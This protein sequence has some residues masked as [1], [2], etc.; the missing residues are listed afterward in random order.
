MLSLSRSSS[1]L[2]EIS[3]SPAEEAAECFRE[4]QSLYHK[5]LLSEATELLLRTAELD[6]T[7]R[8]CRTQLGNLFQ[9]MDFPEHAVH[10]HAEA[11]KLEPRSLLV[12]LN[13]ACVLPLL[14]QSRE[15]VTHYRQRLNQVLSEIPDDLDPSANDGIDINAHLFY[16]AFYDENIRFTIERYAKHLQKYYGRTQAIAPTRNPTSGRIRIGFLSA[17]FFH[18]SHLRAFEGLIRNLDRLRFEVVLIHLYDSTKDSERDK[19]DA[20]CDQ[21]IVLSA[22]ISEAS[23][24]LAGLNLDLLFFTDIGMHPLSALIATGRYAPVQ[25]AGWGVPHTSGLSTIDFYI[26]GDLVEPQDGAD[27]YSEQLVKLP[28]I[29]CCYLSERLELP[30]LDR[31]YFWLPP[32][33]LLVGCLQSFHKLHPDFDT[34]L[35]QIACQVPDAWFVFVE[36]ETTSLTTKFMN[37]LAK[38]APT[39]LERVV[40]LGRTKR[41]EYM[42]LT[43]NLDLIL[44]TFH[45]GSGVTVFETLHTGTPI[46]TMEGRF[47]R[48]RFVAGAYRAIGLTDAPVAKSPEQFVATVVRLLNHREERHQLREKIR[49]AARNHLYDRL[50]YVRGFERFAIE[51]LAALDAPDRD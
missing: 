8:A 13:H 36:A 29:P 51:A 25:V 37:R 6:P 17:F 46:V 22:S 10:W 31:N 39:V 35:E 16:L 48:S 19:L 21:A 43:A 34:A 49:E 30:E 45:Y 32:D 27:H 38:H 47:L 50:D 33:E 18:H 41:D 24:C 2:S 9:V 40:L 7:H 5:G 44:D 20:L 42:A 12:H 3:R 23:T 14:P 28:G 15:E 4:A 1:S 26:S 11:L